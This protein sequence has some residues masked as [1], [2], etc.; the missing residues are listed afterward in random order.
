[1][2]ASDDE[3]LW[4]AVGAGAGAG[5]AAGAAGAERARWAAEFTAFDDGGD[6][7]GWGD[8]PEEQDAA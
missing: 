5:A 8:L 4:A 2:G 7:G 1:V 3:G 6:A